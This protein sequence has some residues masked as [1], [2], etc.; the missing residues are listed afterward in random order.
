MDD[1]N[2]SL[3]DTWWMDCSTFVQNRHGVPVQVQDRDVYHVG[4]W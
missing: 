4:K 1:T 3:N 2:T